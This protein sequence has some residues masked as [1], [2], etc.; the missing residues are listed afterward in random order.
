MF[1]MCASAE[2]IIVISCTRRI[3]FAGEEGREGEGEREVGREPGGRLSGMTT[4]MGEEGRELG[5]DGTMP[6]ERR[7]EYMA[8]G[9]FGMEE[10]MGDVRLALLFMKS[11][12]RG[13]FGEML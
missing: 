12:A 6:G 8:M 2:F 5:W 11:A 13:S 9:E 10:G 7:G 4:G 1:V 3:W